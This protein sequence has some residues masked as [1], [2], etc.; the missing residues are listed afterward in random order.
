MNKRITSAFIVAVMLAALLSG[1]E[2]NTDSKPTGGLDI[3]IS[4]ASSSTNDESNASKPNSS[5]EPAIDIEAIP[6]TPISDFTCKYDSELGGMVITKYNG[7]NA[8]NVKIPSIIE[9][10]KVVKIGNSAFGH[11][12]SAV[13]VVIP[14]SVKSIGNNAFESC[15]KLENVFIPSGITAIE[16]NTFSNCKK[17][18]S[19]NIPDGVTSI[20]FAAFSS[21]HSLKTVKIP[22]SVETIGERAFADCVSLSALDVDVNNKNFCSENG[23]LFNKDKSTLICYP[24]G[25][26]NGEYT[27]PNG[28]A[29][30]QSDAF[31]NNVYIKSVVIPDGVKSIGYQAFMFCDNL[32]SVTIPDSVTSV[33]KEPFSFCKKLTNAAYKGKTYSYSNIKELYAAINGTE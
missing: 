27:V 18:K 19:V 24:A 16:N 1:C 12:D 15:G 8:A 32:E 3:S 22:A 10:N 28:V 23:V 29:A 26:T 13:I 2:G 20:G 25:I 4:H 7:K 17:L 11:A 9:G 14:D 31:A 33:G 21:C 6:E 30:I 5:G